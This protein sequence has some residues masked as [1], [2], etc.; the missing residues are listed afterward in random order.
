MEKDK[1]P[2]IFKLVLFISIKNSKLGKE[3]QFNFT[4]CVHRLIFTTIYNRIVI[5]SSDIICTNVTYK[6]I[7][8]YINY[9]A[10]YYL[11]LFDKK[12][13]KKKK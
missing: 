4:F 7:I 9:L 10:K 2:R 12:K 3:A 13:K 6:I 11:L 8:N 5:N 1:T